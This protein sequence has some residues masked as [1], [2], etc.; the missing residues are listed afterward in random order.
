[1]VTYEVMNLRHSKI[2]LWLFAGGRVLIIE[3]AKDSMGT[4]CYDICNVY[5]SFPFPASCVR[6]ILSS[7]PLQ[8][9]VDLQLLRVVSD[10][11]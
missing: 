10:G 11:T 6:I 3:I 5:L 9:C 4:F 1:M 7:D 8:Y 2:I